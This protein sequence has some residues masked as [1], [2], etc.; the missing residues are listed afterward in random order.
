VY[1]KRSEHLLRRAGALPLHPART[2]CALD[3]HHFLASSVYSPRTYIPMSTAISRWG[4]SLALRLPKAVAEATGI[5]EGTEVRIEAD[6]GRI[7]VTPI[8]PELTLAAL[9]QGVTPD[10]ISGEL[11][12]TPPR[13]RELL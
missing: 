13:G 8:R 12:P 2:L 3:P 6:S 11:D 5:A 1:A 7:V 9:L 4:N 10:R